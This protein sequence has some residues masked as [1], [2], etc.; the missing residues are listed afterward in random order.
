VFQAV[1]W[2]DRASQQ[3][4]GRSVARE[5]EREREREGRRGKEK[6]EE[7]ERVARRFKPLS[8]VK[9]IGVTQSTST[10]ASYG[11]WPSV[12]QAN[13]APRLATSAPG[14]TPAL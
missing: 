3:R 4:R 2:P 13:M 1:W 11:N 8:C 6:R 7:K 5:R 9:H 14:H 10:H 12:T